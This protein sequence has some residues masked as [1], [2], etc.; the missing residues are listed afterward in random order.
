MTLPDPATHPMPAGGYPLVV[1][2]HGCCSGS[3]T[4]WE[5][6]TIDGGGA[7]N[8]HYNNAWFA[9]RGYVV[10]TYTARGFV[11]GSNQGSTGQ[12]QLDSDLFEINDYQHMAGQLADLTDI[13]PVTAGNQIVNGEKVVPTGGSYG[14]GF[15]WMALTDPTWQSPGGK[16]MKVVAAAAKYGWTNLVEALVPRG[17]DRRDALPDTNPATQV[18]LP[19][20]FPKRTIN[21][22]LY[23]SGKTGVPPG[24]PHTTFAADIDAAQACLS[25]ADPYESNPLCS[26][27]L[28]TTLPRFINERSAYFQTASSTGWTT[29]ASTPCR[30]SA[31]APPP[32]SCFPPPSTGGWWSGSKTRSRLPRTPCR[33]TTATTTTSCRT[34]ARSGRTC[35]APTTTPAPTP[36]IPATT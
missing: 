33:S 2:M 15:T 36:T 23:A 17:D 4:S 26:S 10:L 1:M 25:S 29:A 27:T 20:G 32:T 16:S 22:A 24:T 9:S 30:C 21:N 34:S 11:N 12:T 19:T 14:G 31:P 8:W 18:A 28:A 6:A 13:D 5:S 7:E 35:A 3:K